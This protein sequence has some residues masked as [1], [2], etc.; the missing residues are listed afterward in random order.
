MK[1]LDKKIFLF[2]TYQIVTSTLRDPYV[3]PGSRDPYVTSAS[4]DPYVTST[5]RDT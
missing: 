1:I 5:S 4:R 3:T 2:F